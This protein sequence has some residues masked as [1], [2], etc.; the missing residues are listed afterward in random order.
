MANQEIEIKFRVDD[1]EALA[2][3]LRAAGFYE[4]TARTHEMNILYDLPG[5]PLRRRGSL[6]RIRQY[7][8]KWTVT[9][10][11]RVESSDPR[12]KSRREIETTVA[13]GQ[14]LAEILVSAGFK[15]GFAYE[16]FR[17]EWADRTGHVVIDETPIGNF[18]EI[19]GPPQWIDETAGRLQIPPD[20]YITSSYAELFADWKKETGSQAEHMVFQG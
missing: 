2:S 14:K 20:R 4:A 5:E 1:I 18:G 12:H 6:L 13:D 11:D 10:K 16:K 7:G 19:E 8:A 15:P 9:Y 17:T 3:R